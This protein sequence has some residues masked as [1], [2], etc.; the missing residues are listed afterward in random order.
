[1]DPT[2]IFFAVLAAVICFQLFS[3]LGRRDG[4]ETEEEDR[5]LPRSSVE[6]AP[7]PAAH[8]YTPPAEE[9]NLPEWARQVR[10]VYPGFQV[11]EFLTGA[12]AA[13]EMIV[14]AFAQNNL[15]E[16]KPFI[17]PSVYKAF[18]M[19]VKARDDAKQTS[20]LQFVGIEKADVDGTKI[21]GGFVK[22]TVTFFSDQIRVLRDENGDV[23]EGDPNRIDRV[24]DRWTF[25]RPVH[26][27]DPNWQL[28]ATGGHEPAAG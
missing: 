5:P 6:E 18:E 16:V 26:S 21:D 22:V 12:K 8:T 7:E 14:E 24:K 23:I 20:E 13:Y 9:E 2:T 25:S 17:A 15:S 28:V 27:S 11:G 10:D 4:H 19:A 3:V 1:M